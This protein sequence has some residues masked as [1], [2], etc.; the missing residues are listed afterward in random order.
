MSPREAVGGSRAG[1]ETMDRL[2]LECRRFSRY[3]IGAD[4]PA[5]LVA[6]YGAASRVLFPDAATPGDRALLDFADAHPWSLAFL[7]AAAG[8]FRPESLLRKKMLL[9]LAILETTPE[10]AE[11]FEPASPGTLGA[12]LRLGA[13]GLVCVLE[14]ALGALLLS[15]FVRPR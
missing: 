1:F 14:I 7:D 13:T 3:L 8:L 15:V 4:P 12:V 2:S 9:M 5:A 10:Y 11:R 6:R